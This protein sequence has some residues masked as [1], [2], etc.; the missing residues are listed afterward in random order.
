MQHAKLSAEAWSAGLRQYRRGMPEQLTE[1]LVTGIEGVRSTTALLQ[2]VRCADP[3]AGMFEA[4]DFQW[5][6]RKPRS[7]DDRPQ[8]FWVDDQGRPEAAVIA[9]DWGD[10]VGLE[11]LLLPDAAPDFR[12]HVL[13]KGLA[14]AAEQ[15]YS[16]VHFTVATDDTAMV[17]A[18]ADRGFTNLEPEL[19]ETWLDASDRP[20]ISPIADG[21]RLVTRV[22]TASG[23]HHMTKRGE[24]DVERRLRQTSLYRRDLD[25]VVL[26]AHGHPAAYGL[27]WYDPVSSTGLVEPMRTEDDHQ[28]RGLARHVLTSGIP[29]LVE[30]G[31]TRI[32]ICYSDSNPGAKGLYLDVGFVPTRTCWTV[33]AP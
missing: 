23:Q 9:T 15:E 7:T 14:H 10:S 27:F 28:R 11:L 1:H 6:W 8:L 18:L 13:D 12:V 19:V 31:A 24:P 2:R 30:A 29:R 17:A 33:S 25:L 20:D 3:L 26:D 32:K 21:Y 22:D 4:A 5:W 16:P